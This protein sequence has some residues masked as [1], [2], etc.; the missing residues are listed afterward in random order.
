VS[1]RLVRGLAGALVAL[2]AG[3]MT[4][5]PDSEAAGWP[6]ARETPNA[7]AL[8]GTEW[9]LEDLAGRG[10]LDRVPASLG[11]PEA[12]RVAGLLSCNRFNGSVQVGE[13][14]S[15][16][17]GP[18]V[19]TRMGCTPAVMEQEERY[20]RALEAARRLRFDGPFLL[21]DAEGHDRP[22]R[23]TRSR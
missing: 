22:L 20:A 15:V 4:A 9:L 1:G 10:V 16:R 21:L 7:T 23:F 2:G 13:D 8:L 18:L 6:A 19:A 5:S 17:I 12:G 3:C 11:F 14:G